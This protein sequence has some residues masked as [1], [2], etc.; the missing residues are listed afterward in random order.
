V[1]KPT[2]SSRFRSNGDAEPAKG[3]SVS[4][5]LD[6]LEGQ[7]TTPQQHGAIKTLRRAFEETPPKAK[8][9]TPSTP[10]QRAVPNFAKQQ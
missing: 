3:G 1:D 7:A 9:E 2:F 8:R 4:S 6:A 10:G 5:M